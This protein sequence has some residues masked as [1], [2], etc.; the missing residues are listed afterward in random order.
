MK[1]ISKQMNLNDEK[2]LELKKVA[3]G[4]MIINMLFK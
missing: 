4:W 3:Y 2:I 1:Q